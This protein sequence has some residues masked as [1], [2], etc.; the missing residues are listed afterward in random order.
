MRLGGLGLLKKESNDLIGIQSQ[1]LPACDKLK[2]DKV[3]HTTV[4]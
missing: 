4:V 1:D 3:E 2:C